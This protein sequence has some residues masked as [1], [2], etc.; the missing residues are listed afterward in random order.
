MSHQGAAL[1]GRRRLARVGTHHSC[2]TMGHAVSSGLSSL[3][4]WTGDM[5][6]FLLGGLCFPG[7]VVWNTW[8]ASVHEAARARGAALT[9]KQGRSGHSPPH[10]VEEQQRPAVKQ[11]GTV[12]RL[13][14][15]Q[16]GTPLHS[17]LTVF[18]VVLSCSLNLPSSGP[19]QVAGV[20]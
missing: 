13:D 19:R 9:S 8:G 5:D 20:A 15:I 2:R 12:T 3:V 1:R 4:A 17:A 16:K 7:T 14:Y 18:H 6:P 11:S 10:S